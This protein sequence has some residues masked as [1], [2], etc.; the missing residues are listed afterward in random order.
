VISFR[1]ARAQLKSVF[2]KAGFTRRAE[3][4]AVLRSVVVGLAKH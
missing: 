4:V 2:D 3:L 1:T